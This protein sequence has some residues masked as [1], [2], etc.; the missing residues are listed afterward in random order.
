MKIIKRT[1]SECEDLSLAPLC[2]F[3]SF[4]L[5]R[6]S[7]WRPFVS[8][9]PILSRCLLGSKAVEVRSIRWTIRAPASYIHLFPRRQMASVTCLALQPSLT[10]S[11][12]TC[13]PVV[14][15]IKR[16]DS[17]ISE[18]ASMRR[19][20]PPAK[21]PKTPMDR[22]ASQTSTST[23]SHSRSASRSTVR[24]RANSRRSSF[25]SGRRVVP[26]ASIVPVASARSSPQDKRES[27]LALHRE[28]CR[29]FQDTSNRSSIEA[30]PSLRR[31]SSTHPYRRERTS[32]DKDS[33]APS[34][35]ITPTYSSFRFEP[36][37]TSPTSLSAS[38]RVS[39]ESNTMA[40]SGHH[41]PSSSSIHVPATVMEWTSPDTRRREYEKIDRA[42]RGMRGLWRRVAP[43]CFQ[44]RD[45]RTPFF[46]E[47]KPER[48]GSVRRFR[49]DLPEDEPEPGSQS[50][51]QIQLLNFLSNTTVSNSTS[52]SP[53]STRRR[54]ASLRS[55]SS[56]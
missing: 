20:D 25:H 32:S 36:E 16:C 55:K 47:G 19:I 18:M 35:P 41:S 9:S 8:I 4:I 13:D 15:E 6:S 3:H 23:S 24:S 48:E 2:F 56:P 44:T 21:A 46:E 12:K 52:N 54:W 22:R 29:L 5:Q 30:P 10:I 39:R 42:S 49:M 45:A 14:T 27:L 11:T 40:S 17:A 53:D 31:T 26:K 28:S 51:S 33:S 50:K 34:S 37:S 38:H 7:R 1:D 43:R